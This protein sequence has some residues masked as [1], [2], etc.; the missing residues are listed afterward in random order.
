MSQQA[1]DVKK[2]LEVALAPKLPSWAPW[3]I[4]GVL[5]GFT[6]LAVTGLTWP[7]Y[8]LYLLGVIAVGAFSGAYNVAVSLH[9]SAKIMST[10]NEVLGDGTFSEI[11]SLS[12]Y[13]G[14]DNEEG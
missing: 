9:N 5:T 7:I 1:E 4:Y 11:E 14:E 8:G 10:I 13:E 6:Y 3:A 12:T 2:F